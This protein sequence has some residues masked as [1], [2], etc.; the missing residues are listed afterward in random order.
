MFG[1]SSCVDIMVGGPEVDSPCGQKNIHHHSGIVMMQLRR[2]RRPVPRPDGG[3][4]ELCVLRAF[5]AVAS[6]WKR[7]SHLSYE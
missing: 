3:R 7:N 4:V 1:A 6:G 5:G 2:A